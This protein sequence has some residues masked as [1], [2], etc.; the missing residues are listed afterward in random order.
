MN[1][2]EQKEQNSALE[3]A[4][5]EVT[6]REKITTR[7]EAI[8][9]GL[10]HYFTGKPCKNNHISKRLVSSRACTLCSREKCKSENEKRKD[11]FSAYYKTEEYKKRKKRLSNTPEQKARKRERARER[12]NENKE[13]YRKKAME[14]Y[15]RSRESILK[16]K[17][18]R[19]KERW[20]NDQDF[21]MAC[22]Y[23]NLVSRSLRI[24]E[25][26]KASRTED[27][28][29]YT[30]SELKNHIEKQFVG[31]MSWDNWGDIWELDH[32][33][34]ISKMISDGIKDQKIINALP[35][36]KPIYKKENRAKSSKVTQLI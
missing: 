3:N 26:K 16:N 20:E 2:T 30:V 32:I 35:N 36:L 17:S 10:K 25:K 24:L 8:E 9:K 21:K 1:S 23:R 15:W 22:Q 33:T 28:L 12:Y 27:L 7:K 14:K 5:L 34:P 4:K 6:G 13:K 18:K 31:K 29:G 11:Y 19:T